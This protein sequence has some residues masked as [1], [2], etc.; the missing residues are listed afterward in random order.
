MQQSP[1]IRI[2]FFFRELLLNAGELEIQKP[3]SWKKKK[4][5]ADSFLTKYLAEAM[6]PICI[7]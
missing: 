6:T 1:N 5:K 4:K 7:K 3:A 2:D